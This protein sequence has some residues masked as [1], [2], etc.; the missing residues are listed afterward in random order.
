MASWL[1]G[2]LFGLGIVSG[3]LAFGT[4]MA[5]VIIS[6][7]ASSHRYEEDAKPYKI[8]SIICFSLIPVFIIASSVL[9]SV[10]VSVGKI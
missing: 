5:G 4:L 3:I 7:E 6:G 1:Y 2:L 10:C 9:I 8:V